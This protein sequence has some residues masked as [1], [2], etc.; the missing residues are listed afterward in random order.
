MP[1]IK[2]SRE[3]TMDRNDQQAIELLF[4]K[5]AAVE[6][7]APPRDAPA[8][9]YIHERIT[10]QP[11]APYYMAQTIVIQERALA[12][13]EQ[14]LGELEAQ[15]VSERSDAGLLG[16]VFG[17]RGSVPQVRRQE[18][19]GD[20]A[21]SGFLAGAAQTALGVTGG[22]LLG[23]FIANMLGGGK[24]DSPQAEDRNHETTGHDEAQV[25]ETAFEDDGD[26]GDMEV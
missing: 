7:N 17:E 20:R 8:E 18:V 15:G 24:S 5:L 13:A 2:A 1:K 25:D 6:R 11:A 12:T 4:Q 9:A 23:N 21:G 14:R 26:F 19:T 22:L 3:E 16:G 10:Q